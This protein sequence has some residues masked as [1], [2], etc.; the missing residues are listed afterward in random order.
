MYIRLLKIIAEQTTCH[1][2]AENINTNFKVNEVKIY[3]YIGILMYTSVYRYPNLESYW[4]ENAFAPI[5]NTMAVKRFMVIKKHLSFQDEVSRKRKGQLG[6]DPI[7]RI[8]KF[9]TTLNARFDSIPKT[10]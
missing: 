1:A 4:S 7:F 3:R 6:Y 5:A 8:R 10:A 2:L 9:A